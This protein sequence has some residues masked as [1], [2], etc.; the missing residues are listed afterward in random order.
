MKKIFIFICTFI[1]LYNQTLIAGN[2]EKK[3]QAGATE[4]LINPWAR[5]SG[6]AGANIAGIRGV[7]AIRLNIAGLSFISG[8]E[9]VFSSTQWMKGTDIKI[10]SFGFAQ[11]LGEY[12]GVL[13]LSIMAI[14]FG[15]FIETTVDQPEG[16]GVIFK[17]QFFNM[18]ISYAKTF[19]HSIYGGIVVRVI[20]ESI[21]SVNAT[22]IAFDAGIQYVTGKKDQLKF[23]VSLR[24][25][26]PKMRYSGD[27]LT[28]KG[29]FL[30]AN[31][32]EAQSLNQRATP[33]EM[34][35]LLNIGAAY[36]IISTEDGDH[37]LTAAANFNSNSFTNDQIQAGLEY[38][39]KSYLMLRGGFDYQKNIFD[40]TLRTTVYT[41]PTFGL[42]LQL[43]FGKEKDK[44]FGI[45]YSYRATNPFDGTHSIGTALTF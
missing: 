11:N 23:G 35:S 4:L 13:G 22:G 10:S 41:G 39:F 27:G 34:P 24:N 42:T 18:G 5:S 12:K 3:G 16:T 33:F 40:K 7:E 25:V 20:S 1:V 38:G 8:T 2:E 28:N 9:V 45:D 14:N 43:P 30:D 26:G 36:D 19:S 21:Q 15:E 17:P 31:F 29:S 6:W 37:R 44:S 32:T